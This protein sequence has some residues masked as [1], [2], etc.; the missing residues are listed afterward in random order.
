MVLLVPKPACFWNIER[1]GLVLTEL[2][3]YC[4]GGELGT[5]DRRRGGFFFFSGKK[6]SYVSRRERYRLFFDQERK[7]RRRKE[8]LLEEAKELSSFGGRAK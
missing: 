6:E 7:W 1:E 2:E 5:R 4:F 3:T 8:K